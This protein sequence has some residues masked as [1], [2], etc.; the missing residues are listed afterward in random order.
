MKRPLFLLPL[1]WL[2]ACEPAQERTT[3][4]LL[5]DST[6]PAGENEKGFTIELDE[7]QAVVGPVRFFEGQ[8]LLSRRFSPLDLLVRPAYAHPGHYVPGESMGEWM[9]TAKVDLLLASATPL[10]TVEAV[11]G[12]YGSMQ[13][14][15]TDVVLKGT[16]T[17]GALVVPFE[18]TLE[19]PM[20]L[21]GIRAEGTV[22]AA[23]DSARLS[24]DV[25]KWLHR[26]DF[27]T[28][29]SGDDGVFQ[30]A[31]STQSYNAL[32]RAVADTGAYT[33]VFAPK[34]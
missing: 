22:T 13:L 18:A 33:V 12:D 34:E 16:A 29:E 30:L 19:R 27:E 28:A 23:T 21:E 10:G 11:T 1:L 5:L 24:I 25:R 8:V 32:F 14:V 2:V 4:I 3:Y 7:A 6:L 9:G 15:L 26:V 20:H 17:K 31:P